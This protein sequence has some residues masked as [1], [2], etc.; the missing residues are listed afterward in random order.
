MQVYFPDSESVL[1]SSMLV[2]WKQS[3]S[4]YNFRSLPETAVICVDD[5]VMKAFRT[6][7]ARTIKGIKGRHFV[8]QGI[9]F[10]SSFDNGGAGIL[11]LLE[12]LRALGVQRFVFVGLAGR[13]VPGIAEGSCFS[14]SMAISGTGV[15]RYYHPGGETD[16]FNKPFL[17]EMSSSLN[18]GSCTCFST[19]APFRET[20]P[21]LL[22]CVARGA[23]LIEMECA[24]VYAFSH[25][26]RVDA[27]CLLIAADTLT[28][29]WRSPADFP[30]LLK[31]QSE[32]I[33]GLIKFLA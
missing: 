20:P 21:L 29:E 26:Y 30:A 4:V 16:P 15:T 9:L 11:N 1:Q 10:S 27:A 19:D 6:F 32:L 23:M 13:L 17:Q 25:F 18:I 2:A 22:Q 5:A 24:A 3:R 7:R 8:Q 14:V 28:P 33:Q 31:K 12:E